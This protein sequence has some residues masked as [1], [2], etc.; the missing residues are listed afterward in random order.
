M[1]RP[2]LLDIQNISIHYHTKRGSLEAVHQASF[3]IDHQTS[4]A[5]IGE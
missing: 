5:V 1:Q 2:P 3:S 4:V